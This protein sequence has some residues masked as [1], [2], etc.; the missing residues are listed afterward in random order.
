M[1]MGCSMPRPISD[2]TSSWIFS[3]ERPSPM[4]ALA[5]MPSPSRTR[6]SRICSVPMLLW[7]R[8]T[9][10]SWA[11][12]ST[13][14]ARSVNLPNIMVQ[15]LRWNGFSP[16]W[17]HSVPV[18]LRNGFPGP[19]AS[20]PQFRT[21]QH[22]PADVPFFRRQVLPGV[23]LQESGLRHDDEFHQFLRIHPLDQPEFAAEPDVAEPLRRLLRIDDGGMGK[24]AEGPVDAVEDA[25]SRLREQF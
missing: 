2:S 18:P 7:P 4:S 17:F 15:H 1:L 25:D 11:S 3:R 9:A 14:W 22:R 19:V 10:S 21:D 12:A 13:F 23:L 8:R 24:D 20:C 5:A 16:R 6:P